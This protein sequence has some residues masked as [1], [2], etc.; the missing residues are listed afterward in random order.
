[1]DDRLKEIIIS[2]T[3]RCNLR[4]AMCQIPDSDDSGEMNTRQL[5]ALILDAISLC[6][7]SIVFSGGE[8]LLRKDIFDMIALVNQNRINT[9]LTSNGT[10]SPF[11]FLMWLM[12]SNIEIIKY[13][14]RLSFLKYYI[15][16]FVF[17]FKHYMLWY[18]V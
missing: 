3:N 12:F 5:E 14:F 11:L 10:I 17:N 9:C 13:L 18:R 6:P 4:C 8:P 7:R 1:M 16:C 2:V 15:L